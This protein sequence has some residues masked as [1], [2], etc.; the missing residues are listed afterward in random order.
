MGLATN[1]D[2][3]RLLKKINRSYLFSSTIVLIIG[4][5]AFYFLIKHI[6]SRESVEGLHASEIRIVHELRQNKTVLR[7]YPLIEVEQT[8]KTG[9]E[10]VKDTTIFDPIEGE[11]E[12]FK[13]LNTFWEVN[14]KDYHITIMALSVEKEGIAMTIFLSIKAIF[15]C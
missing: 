2:G 13:E 9:P 14:G 8:Q 7:L 12:V 15:C 5:L 1:G 11:D 6:A 3:M 10:F 4:L